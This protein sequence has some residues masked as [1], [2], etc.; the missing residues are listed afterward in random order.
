MR[1][2]CLRNGILK[3]RWHARNVRKVTGQLAGN[4]H[5]ALTHQTSAHAGVYR[6]GQPG[7]LDPDV[8]LFCAL[9]GRQLSARGLAGAP[10]LLHSAVRPLPQARAAVGQVRQ[11]PAWLLCLPLPAAAQLQGWSARTPNQR[12]VKGS[13]RMQL[14]DR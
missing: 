2:V 7:R 10:L 5:Q 8:H 6:G 13:K 11:L 3:A 9:T 12:P 4:P 14:W 1:A